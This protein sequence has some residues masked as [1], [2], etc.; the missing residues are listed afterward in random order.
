MNDEF[1]LAFAWSTS[2]KPSPEGEGFSIAGRWRYSTK[3]CVSR[4]YRTSPLLSHLIF[5]RRNARLLNGEGKIVC[6]SC[7]GSSGCETHGVVFK[8]FQISIPLNAYCIY[9]RSA[10]IAAGLDEYWR[11]PYSLHSANDHP[12]TSNLLT[13]LSGQ[14]RWRSSDSRH[15]AGH[16]T[17]FLSR[18][19]VASGVVPSLV[20]PVIPNCQSPRPFVSFF[21]RFLDVRKW[22]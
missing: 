21:E 15:R 10:I 3:I 14:A 6:R 7:R 9:I 19:L 2:P 1:R 11:Q 16:L 17:P 5:F 20:F 4:T 22:I 12:P 8:C 13:L 18:I